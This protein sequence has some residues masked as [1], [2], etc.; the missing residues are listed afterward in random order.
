MGKLGYFG[1]RL[2]P[3]RCLEP[4]SRS[5]ALVFA[6]ANYD[7]SAPLCR[8]IW[9]DLACIE[10]KLPIHELTI[11]FINKAAVFQMGNCP[12][13]QRMGPWFQKWCSGCNALFIN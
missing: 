5:F 3:Q 12:I 1:S 13:S 9:T 11:L 8:K 7:E 10:L 4:F 6:P 2:V